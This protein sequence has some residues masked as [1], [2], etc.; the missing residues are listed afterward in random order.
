MTR[1]VCTGTHQF[2]EYIRKRPQLFSDMIRR[3]KSMDHGHAILRIAR[4]LR[5]SDCTGRFTPSSPARR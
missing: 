3:V 4:D 1:L 5:D 2:E